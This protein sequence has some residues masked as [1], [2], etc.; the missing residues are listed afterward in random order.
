MI[1]LQEPALP[2]SPNVFSDATEH[3]ILLRDVPWEVYQS[4]RSAEANN[5]LRMTYDGGAL[6][7]MSPSRKHGKISTFVAS[8]ITEWAVRHELEVEFG[9]DTTFRREDLRRGLEPDH[10]FWIANQAAVRGKD[11]IDLAVDPPPDLVLE[12]EISRSAISKLPIYQ[13]LRVPEVWRWHQEQL[14]VLTLAANE[15]YS[16]Q[17]NSAA[18]PHFPLQIAEEFIRQRKHAS[19][20]ALIRQF[21]K[22]IA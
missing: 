5:H 22:A 16:P 20:T 18:L 7:I 2:P 15:E 3:S 6:E 12:I 13:A 21:R 17:T 1:A 11:E 14:N 10:C 19:D 8:L 4:L 9:G